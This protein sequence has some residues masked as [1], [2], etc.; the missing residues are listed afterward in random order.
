MDIGMLWFDD[1]QRPLAEKV[2]RAA[3]HYAA[4]YGA[5]PTVCFVNPRTLN[6]G[7]ETAAG[8]QLRAARNVMV[9][10]FWIGVDLAAGKNGNGRSPN[11]S[12]AGKAS[13]RNGAEA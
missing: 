6:G 12:T 11:G 13:R 2:A 4:K 5:T 7:P 10:H 3:Q 8:V 9:D 1:T